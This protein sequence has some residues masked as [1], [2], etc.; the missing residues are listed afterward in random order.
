M[1]TV[2]RCKCPCGWEFSVEDAYSRLGISAALTA[3]DA[4]AQHVA[5]CE[6]VAA[7]VVQPVERA[8]LAVGAA[9][10]SARLIEGGQG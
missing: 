8:M 6:R 3:K 2:I 1:T 9:K 7:V 10:A 5:V 4:Y